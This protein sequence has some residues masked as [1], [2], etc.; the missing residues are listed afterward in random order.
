[1]ILNNE[2]NDRRESKNVINKMMIAN[3]LVNGLLV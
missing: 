1:M 3:P 2:F